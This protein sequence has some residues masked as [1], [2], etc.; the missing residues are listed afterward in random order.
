VRFV[1]ELERGKSTARL[2]ETLRVVASLGLSLTIG[3]PD[4][5]ADA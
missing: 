2:G 1:S 4:E 3:D 5:Y